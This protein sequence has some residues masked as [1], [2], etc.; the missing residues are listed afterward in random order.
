MDKYSTSMIRKYKLK[1]KYIELSQMEIDEMIMGSDII[2]H[3]KAYQYS[4]IN[5]SSPWF[6]ETPKKIKLNDDKP[7]DEEL[8]LLHY[9]DECLVNGYIH[10]QDNIQ[11]P[12]MLL[13]IIIVYSTTMSMVIS[14]LEN[15]KIFNWRLYGRIMKNENDK[16]NKPIC[17]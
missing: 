10:E 14:K 11:L 3:F 4:T 16:R 7:M 2:W 6:Q 5:Q 15:I 12:T 9:Y 8:E 1:S 13:Q 17:N